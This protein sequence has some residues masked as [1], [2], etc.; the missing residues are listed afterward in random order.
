MN[1]LWLAQREKREHLVQ[2]FWVKQVLLDL[3]LWATVHCIQGE[4]CCARLIWSGRA[5]RSRC[6][7]DCHAAHAVIV[8]NT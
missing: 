2:C 3:R 8:W 7:A 1:L 6:R 4:R 5:W